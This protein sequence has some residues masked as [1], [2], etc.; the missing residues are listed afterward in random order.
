MLQFVILLRI[1]ESAVDCNSLQVGTFGFRSFRNLH[2]N[3]SQRW[4]FSFSCTAM[5]YTLRHYR[6]L[7]CLMTIRSS[8]KCRQRLPLTVLRYTILLSLQ[9]YDNRCVDTFVFFDLVC[10]FEIRS[11]VSLYP[12]CTKRRYLWYRRHTWLVMNSCSHSVVLV[13][14]SS[15]QNQQQVW[16]ISTSFVLCAFC[17]VFILSRLWHNCRKRFLRQYWLPYFY[18]ITK[19]FN[20]ILI[21][22]SSKF[23]SPAHACV[24]FCMCRV[25]F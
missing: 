10:A 6:T 24:L 8:P 21:I 7:T 18:V 13:T 25:Q 5:S 16:E 11:I 9:F 17:G 1:T 23:Y 20:P 14:S 2:W 3:N 12:L 19:S 4:S 15:Y 22:L